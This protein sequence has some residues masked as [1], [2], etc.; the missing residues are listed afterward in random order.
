[1]TGNVFFSDMPTNWIAYPDGLGIA[2]VSVTIFL[3]II[4]LVT[5][6]LRMWVRI[7]SGAIGVDDYLMAVGTGIFTASSIFCCMDVYAGLGSHDDRQDFTDWNKPAVIM[8][9][10]PWQITYAWCLLFI[11][12]SICVSLFRITA[13]RK[14]RLMLWGVMFLASLSALIGFIAV[15]ITCNPIAKNW[16]PVLAADS[17]IGYCIDYNIIQGISYYISASS[18]ITDWACAVIPCF[19][20][21]NLQMRR[22]LKIS[23]VGILALGAVASLTTIIRLPYLGTYTATSDRYYQ[24]CN[25][26]IWS[27]IECGVGIIAASLP[28]LRRLV[29]NILEKSSSRGGSYHPR[30]GTDRHTATIGGGKGRSHSGKIS[31][32]TKMIN[33]SR[34]GGNTTICA[35]DRDTGCTWI[36]LDDD[37]ESQKHIITQTNEV[38]V[39]VEDT[40]N[41]GGISSADSV[42]R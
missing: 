17:S 7:T 6:S 39:S 40:K 37:S 41:N 15:V 16:D 22:K 8:Y 14:F 33:L 25:I 29:K 42:Q 27:Q 13:E 24:V 21:W 3:A 4:C 28:S 32:S 36:E 18:I 19:I 26:V 23:V 34:P 10:I 12:C 11:K 5:A 30:S 31:R 38:S 20:V 2:C 1:M 9:L 35:A